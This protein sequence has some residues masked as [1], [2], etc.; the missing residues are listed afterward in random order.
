MAQVFLEW[1]SGIVRREMDQDI[2]WLI[3]YKESEN[4]MKPKLCVTDPINGFSSHIVSD[5]I[6]ALLG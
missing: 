3:T 2:V 4:V 6:W 5:T 1:L